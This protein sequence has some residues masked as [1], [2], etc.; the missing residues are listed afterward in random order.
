MKEP[1]DHLVRPRLPW[2]PIIEGAITE[3]GLDALTAKTITRE[4]YLQRLRDYGKQR[5][6]MLTCMTCSQTVER[7]ET[8]EQDPRKAIGR[9]V[10]WETA[11]YVRAKDRGE[12]LRDE[13]LAIAALIDAHQEEFRQLVTSAH[14]R[15][16]WL[17]RKQQQEKPQQRRATWRPVR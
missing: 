14:A 16:D 15:R 5:T 13:L 4:Q 8:W 12:L 17:A 6:A 3:C 7:W 1:V 10:E 9:E 2:R 11:L